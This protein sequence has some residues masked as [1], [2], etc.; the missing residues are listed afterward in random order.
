[1]LIITRKIGEAVYLFPSDDIP[2]DM[3]VK[4][5]FAVNQISVEIAS[6][7]ASQVKIGIDAPKT[8]SILRDDAKVPKLAKT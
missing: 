1:M 4:E 3:T 5:F 6:I 2:D 7:S 8:I